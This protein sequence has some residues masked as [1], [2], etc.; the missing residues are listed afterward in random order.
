M[1]TRAGSKTGILTAAAL[2]MLAVGCRKEGV[3]D[4]GQI[5]AAVGEVMTSADE[6]A[7][8]GAA[9]A[10]LPALPVA[11]VLRA[12][13]EL[14]PP[15]WR[16]AVDAL[17]LIPP[18]YADSC[19]PV[20][21]SACS[22]GVRTATFNGCTVGEIAVDGAVNLTFSDAA[23]CNIATVGD[24]VNRTGSLTLSALGG[25]LAITTPGGGQ[26]LTRTATGFTF[27]VPGMERVLT[28]PSGRTLFD[29]STAT[30]TPLTI[31]GSS[32]ADMVMVGGTLVVTHN[33]AGYSVSLTPDHLAWTPTC[34]C[35]SSGSLTG[36][37]SGGGKDDGKSATVT[38][39][40]CGTA[41]VTI[42]GDSESV[43]MDRCAAI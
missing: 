6:S 39:T 17:T 31:T 4:Q 19:L 21:Y 26:T 9:T 7:N 20:T 29:I 33:L 8:G 5:G 37:V 12:P 2:A 13:A 28:L 22:A 42:D 36:T 14:R 41:D 30:T 16:R 38:I 34:N 18:A 11:P 15:L 3:S 27:A 25:S 32:R 23:A 40:G 24:S 43:T 35:A 10:M 1:L